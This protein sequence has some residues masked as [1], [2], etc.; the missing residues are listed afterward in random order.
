MRI[1][2][3]LVHYLWPA[4]A[5]WLRR[6]VLA[7]MVCLVAAKLVNIQ[8]RPPLP[9]PRRRAAPPRRCAVPRGLA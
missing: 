3:N 2:Q 7:S 1:V 5:P 8:A 9:Q 6:R 4:D